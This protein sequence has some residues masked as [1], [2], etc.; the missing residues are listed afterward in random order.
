MGSG[1]YLGGSTVINVGSAW[2]GK[3][4]LSRPKKKK[5]K[6]KEINIKQLN[7]IR[8]V[9]LRKI[10]K[11]TDIK[12]MKLSRKQ[13]T[14]FHDEIRRKGGIEKWAQSQS[15]YKKILKK[16]GPGRYKDSIG[17][18]MP[19]EKD[20]TRNQ[21]KTIKREK[22]LIDALRHEL[23]QKISR[24]EGKWNIKYLT[25]D[26]KIALHDEIMQKGGLVKWAESQSI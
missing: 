26:Q 13:K 23:L 21:P 12:N 2:S 18:G 16:F 1:S 17:K 11:T 15:Q 10:A 3:S 25:N 14:L 7:R 20:P 8:K 19:P 22:R 4:G 6:E 5:E 24:E 9:L